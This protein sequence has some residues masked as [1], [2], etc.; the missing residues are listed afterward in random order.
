MPSSGKKSSGFFAKF[1]TMVS[2]LCLVAVLVALLPLAGQPC[3]FVVRFVY[4]FND[5]PAQILLGV[6]RPWAEGSNAFWSVQDHFVW[7]RGAMA[8]LLSRGLFG[9]PNFTY[10]CT[11][12]RVQ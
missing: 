6:A 11:P 3:A 1:M 12:P 7:Q 10:M 2:A 8:D 4:I 9:S 5:L